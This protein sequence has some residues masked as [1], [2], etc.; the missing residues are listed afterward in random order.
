[1]SRS[2]HSPSAV[3]ARRRLTRALLVAAVLATGLSVVA[4]NE[5]VHADPVARPF[6][7]L[8]CKYSDKP[9]TY[10]FGASDIQTMLTGGGG[11]DVDG[12]VQEMSLGAVSI[13]GSKAAGWFDLPKP[14]TAYA[15]SYAGALAITQD[16]AT[17]AQAGGVDMSSFSN[18]MVFLNDQ[19]P[20]AE[21]ETIPA[22][23][24]V[25]GQ[26]KQFTAIDL[27]WRGLNSPPLLLH[28]LGHVFAGSKHTTGVT[29]PLGYAAYGDHLDHPLFGAPRAVT[30]GPGWDAP[31]RDAAGWI[32][33]DRKATFTGG[34][35]TYTLTRLT[36]PAPD[37]LMMVNVPIPGT[38]DKYVVAARTRTGYDAQLSLANGSTQF[39][40]ALVQ[41]GVR[42]DR[43]FPTADTQAQLST[44]GGDPLSAA[45]VWVG[46]QT[47]TDSASGISIA[48]TRFDD[49]GAE[50][51]VTGPGGGSAPT[52]TTTT[53]VPVTASPTT[54]SPATTTPPDDGSAA[55]TTTP[56]DGTATTVPTTAAPTTAP[57]TTPPDPTTGAVL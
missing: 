34:T 49:D 29:D 3:P 35:Q 44:P 28:E 17:S 32:P 6:I 53:A 5:P 14:S 24:T 45:E 50:I 55:T 43:V 1:M 46:G 20:G 37:G 27:T 31:T 2:T 47:F 26:P 10:G 36:Q 25:G 52:T 9:N 41:T 51:T 23:L 56:D 38:N 13:A 39:G 40:Y 22:T 33:D 16:C 18:V 30:V 21:G 4:G 54:I 57:A 8:L 7:A 48:I 42:I 11:K 15:D 19:L 12:Y